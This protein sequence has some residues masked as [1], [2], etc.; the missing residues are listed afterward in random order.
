MAKLN[1]EYFIA[2]R[3]RGHGGGYG[4]GGFGLRS[5]NPTGEA[6]SRGV[7]SRI[8]VA[9]TA[10]SIAV[11]IVA[12]AVIMGFRAEISGK[13]TAFTGH[14]KVQ[15]LDYGASS[16]TSP[17][18]LSDALRDAI[19]AVDGVRTVAPYALKPGMA[20]TNEATQGIILKGV[21][22]AAD[23]SFFER[24]LVAGTLPRLTNPADSVR[25]KDILISESVGRMLRLGVDDR[26]E[27]LFIEGERPRRDRFRVSGLYSSG[28]GELDESFAI[29][30][31]A[32][33]RR[34]N[35]WAA[36]EA[37]GYE[38]GIGDFGRLAAT[39][40]ALVAAIL[41]H[42]TGSPPLMVRSV[43]GDF[44]LI[45]DWLATH[46]V[47]AAVIIVIMIVV[48]LVSM[49]SALLIILLERIR[50]IGILKTLGMRN[51]RLRRIFV[52]RASRIVI[53]GLVTG[54]VV[55]V[56]LALVQRATGVL[57]LDT[58]GYFVS[59]VPIELGW[60]W[61]AALNV[62]VAV[63]LVGLMIFPTNI[64]GRISPEKTV[65]YQ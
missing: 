44:P 45:F 11:M 61:I 7:M 23:L 28:F 37:T 9:T 27:M 64:V 19:A 31:I 49:I 43:T 42:D 16:E 63:V 55:G 2:R 32:S 35:G 50:M 46:D 54:D 65:R 53:A 4:R 6:D 47:N 52:I 13:I 18:T 51:G 29:V 21:D 62:G 15:A 59:R 12:V 48:A 41:P 33:V 30:D 60:W 25:H 36:D 38:V 26:I 57:K 56:G 5:R 58:T 1:I 24:W 40:Q 20:K 34:L 39:E 17:I 10:I 14:L 8:A 3:L 22:G